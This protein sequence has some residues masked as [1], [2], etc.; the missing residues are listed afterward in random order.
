MAH[1]CVQA[2]LPK[3]VKRA[4]T[5][6]VLRR[7]SRR[8]APKLRVFIESLNERVFPDSAGMC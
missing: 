5:F 4:G 6:R 1:D 7:G 3:H 2:V 8:L